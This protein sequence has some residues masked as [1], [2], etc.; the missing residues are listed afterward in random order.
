MSDD[1][2]TLLRTISWFTEPPSVLPEHIGDWLMETSSMTQRLE[3]YCVQLR[4]TLCREGFI[5]PQSLGEER[6]QLP[7]DERYWLREVVLYG[8]DRPW[9]FGRTIV[10]QQT[11]DGSGAALVKIG[12]QPLG[13]YLFE[14]KS[15]TRD[16][17]HTGCCEGLWARRS[18]LCLS[19]HPLLLT[20][21][22]LPES[23]VYYT[24]SDEGWQ[25]I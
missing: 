25:V 8:D 13:R 14:Q 24:P 11:L 4:V 20:E 17:I 23:P 2:S 19:G 16:Y 1:V 7:L 21:L 18:R 9:L 5:T 15:L 6:D 3:K 22:F 12:N 10:P